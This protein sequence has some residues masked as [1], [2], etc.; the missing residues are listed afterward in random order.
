MKSPDDRAALT[1][2]HAAHLSRTLRARVGQEFEVVVR[3]ARCGAATVSSVTDE[4]VEFALGEE[5]RGVGGNA[6]HAAA[7]GLQVRPHGV[8][9]R[10]MHGV[11]RDDDRP[12]DRTPHREAPRTGSGEAGGALAAHRARSLGA[13]ATR[14]CTGDSD[15]VKLSAAIGCDY[16]RIANCAGRDM[17]AKRS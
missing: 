4:R 8:G 12:G 17:N 11:E 16:G 3:R 15:P 5:V 7:G 2:E 9:D 14:G 10:E 6:D 13:V 1:G